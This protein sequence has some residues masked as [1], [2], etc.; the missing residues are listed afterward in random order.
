MKHINDGPAKPNAE[1]SRGTTGGLDLAPKGT[2]M[3]NDRT[4]SLST[5]THIIAGIKEATSNRVLLKKTRHES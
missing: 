4:L 5:D 2:D 3:S 1:I